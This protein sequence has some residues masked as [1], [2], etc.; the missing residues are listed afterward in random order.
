[1]HQITKLK[2]LPN[3]PAT[4]YLGTHV[5]A[6]EQQMRQEFIWA[7]QNVIQETA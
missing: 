7:W 5:Y 2:I 1:M 6:G 4:W 3:F